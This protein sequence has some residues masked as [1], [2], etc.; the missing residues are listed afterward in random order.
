[1]A[2]QPVAW[3]RRAEPMLGA[4]ARVFSSQGVV[5]QT[6]RLVPVAQDEFSPTTLQGIEDT[7]VDSEKGFNQAAY[8]LGESLERAL[9]ISRPIRKVTEA[10]EW[11][12]TERRKTG[13]PEYRSPDVPSREQKDLAG[14]TQREQNLLHPC[15]NGPC[16]CRAQVQWV[17]DA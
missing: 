8:E 15:G 17:S 4:L 7:P 10:S 3:R 2:R 12:R 1:M 16:S 14:A 13:N 5:M 11:T 9:G 6:T